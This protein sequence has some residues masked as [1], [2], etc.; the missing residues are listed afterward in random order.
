MLVQYEA[1]D[2]RENIMIYQGASKK[3]MINAI[4]DHIYF[5][6]HINEM[7]IEEEIVTELD[8]ERLNSIGIKLYQNRI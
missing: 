3:E 1:W 7:M 8:E 4:A 2:V 5:S 6:N